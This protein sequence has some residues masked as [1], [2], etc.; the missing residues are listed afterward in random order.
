MIG[1]N[2]LKIG[3]GI[4]ENSAGLPRIAKSVYN[5]KGLLGIYHWYM[6]Y[7]YILVG[8]INQLINR[9]CPTMDGRFCCW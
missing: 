9:G 1:Y 6:I 7:I 4:G 3:P 8:V 2:R 5:Y